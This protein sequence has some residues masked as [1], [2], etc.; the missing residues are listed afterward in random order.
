MISRRQIFVLALTKAATAAPF[1]LSLRSRTEAFRGS[2]DWQEVAFSR[3]LEAERCALVLCDLWDRH[4]CRGAT[5]RVNQLV[6]R[7]AKVVAKFRERGILVV[8]APSDTMSFYKASPERLAILKLPKAQP[9]VPKQLSDPPLP[10]DDSDGGC[11]TDD[12]QGRAWSRQHPGIPVQRGDFISDN[13][14]EIYSAM[15]LRGITTLFV[16]GVHTNM[17]V[18]NRSFAI[19]QMTRWGVRC[20]LI[21]DL[22]DAMYDPKDRPYVS[23]QRGTELVVEHIEKYWAPTTT[24]DQL[25]RA[26]S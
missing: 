23:H 11:D 12:P 6:P 2:E 16:A 13:G 1:S 5:E 25:L 10:V 22:T 21:R 20:I 14:E 26:L 7:V 9:P 19:R 8:H 17:C 24:S 3:T 18:L 4:W 15:K